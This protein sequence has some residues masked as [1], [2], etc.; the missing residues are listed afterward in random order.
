MILLAKLGIGLAGTVLVGGAALCSEGFIDVKV[1][2]K[3]AGGTNVSLVVPAAL[4]PLTL[5]FVPAEQL[6]TAA[7]DLK[8]YLP[9]LDAA[10]PALEDS[11]DG[12]L[13][14]V[15]DPGEHVKIAKLGGS[16]VIDVHDQEDDVHVAVP[17]RAAQHSIHEIAEAQQPK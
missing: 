17:L 11:P 13:V 1:H 10:I 3:H 16:I 2:E 6:G 12:L 5:R 4:A 7:A 9:I 15:V 8:P 14:E